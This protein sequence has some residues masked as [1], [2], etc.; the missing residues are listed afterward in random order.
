MTA[1][2]MEAK[3]ITKQELQNSFPTSDVLVKWSKGEDADWPPINSTVGMP[4][5]RFDVGQKVLCRIGPDINKDW[6]PGTVI[7]LWYREITWPEGSY[8]PYKVKLD[9]GRDIFAPADMDQVIRKQ[10]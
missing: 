9:D 2:A 1:L 5:L 8:A 6:A 7:L 4:S 10:T 3:E